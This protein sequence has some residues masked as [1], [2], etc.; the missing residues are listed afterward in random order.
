L[1]SAARLNVNHFSAN[2]AINRVFNHQNL[3]YFEPVWRHVISNN[4]RISRSR[5]LIASR[6][7]HETRSGRAPK[8]NASLVRRGRAVSKGF[9]TFPFPKAF[10]MHAR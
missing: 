9:D 1:A 10:P 4:L 3:L 6:R 7:N 8:L 5:N 2:V